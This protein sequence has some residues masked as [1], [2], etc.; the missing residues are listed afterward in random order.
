M[1]FVQQPANFRQ[2]E[3]YEAPSLL[4]CKTTRHALVALRQALVFSTLY[5]PLK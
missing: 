4:R 2:G 3:A 5:L 1:P